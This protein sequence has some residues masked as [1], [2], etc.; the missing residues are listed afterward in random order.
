MR[1]PHPLL[2]SLFAASPV[3]LAFWDA[4]L[5]YQRIN[6]SLAAINGLGVEE[7]IGRTIDEVLPEVGPEIEEMLR[8][9]RDTGEA[10]VDLEIRGST[11]AAPGVERT[12]LASYYPVRD[13]DGQIVGVG[14]VVSDI[15]ERKRAEAALAVAHSRTQLL[16]AA[17]RL[18]EST[19]DRVLRLLVPGL[20]DLAIVELVEPDGSIAR[21]ALAAADA[22][23][24]AVARTVEAR[25]PVDPRAD[26][27][28]PEVIRSGIPLLVPEVTQDMVE[29]MAADDEHLAMLRT[30]G[31][32]SVIVVPLRARGKTYGALMLAMIG[33]GRR[34][35]ADELA[36]AEELAERCALAVDNARLYAERSY[37]ARGWQFMVGDV[38]GKGPVA[39]ASTGLVRHTLRALSRYESSPAA[40]LRAANAALLE[41]LPADDF[42]TVAL[43]EVDVA[44][45]RAVIACAGH[46][47][48]LLVREG[49]PVREVGRHG[50]LLGAVRDPEIH[51]EVIALE[52]RDVLLLYTDGVVEARDE[53]GVLGEE[54]LRALVEMLGARAPADLT[55]RLL[56]A[57]AAFERVQRDDVALV[58]LRL[59]PRSDPG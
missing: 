56:R 19:L 45:G 35:G 21:V 51:D 26:F 16:A 20:A 34:Y 12:W 9:V 52:P 32:R 25:Y 48:P 15:T 7:H 43:L 11:P 54:R 41:Q 47:L 13:D 50:V 30:L 10:V 1:T 53:H 8:R 57:V 36:L 2:D 29:R 23:H 40:V 18:L 49:E 39:A 6:E 55:E 3:G 27:G 42:C 37:V 4:D 24:E 31:V 22:E 28:A 58:A 59:T 33:S 14:A 17:S 44:A 5:R 46:P 38:A